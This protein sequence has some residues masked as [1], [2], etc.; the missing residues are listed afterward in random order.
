LYD[1]EES[2][3]IR[4]HFDS[5]T[6][7]NVGLNINCYHFSKTSENELERI[8]Y[9]IKNDIMKDESLN[10]VSKHVRNVAPNKEMYV[11]MYKVHFKHLLTAE[12]ASLKS[13]PQ[14][15]KN[16]DQDACEEIPPA[17]IAK[18]EIVDLIN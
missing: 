15:N 1:K 17:K 8:Q 2:N 10:I 16:E 4:S 14:K 18:Y 3:T 7:A 5:E 13:E 11:T 12:E 9:K 6:L